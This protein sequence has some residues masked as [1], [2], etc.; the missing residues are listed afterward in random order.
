MRKGVKA[1]Y[2]FK[3]MRAP[4]PDKKKSPVKKTE[5]GAGRRKEGRDE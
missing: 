5:G 3:R 1:L 4:R 2:P